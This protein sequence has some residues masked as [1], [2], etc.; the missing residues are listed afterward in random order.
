V[1]DHATGVTA[2]G[3]VSIPLVGTASL[4]GS[5][6]VSGNALQFSLTGS[7]AATFVGF[8]TTAYLTLSNAGM[9][10]TTRLNNGSWINHNFAGYVGS[11]GS[12]DISTS[13]TLNL[14]NFITGQ[15]GIATTFRF[16]STGG[17]VTLTSTA[18]V[19]LL[20]FNVTFAGNIS[21]SGFSFTVRAPTSGTQQACLTLVIVRGCVNYYYQFTLGSATGLNVQTFGSASVEVWVLGFWVGGDVG[22]IGYDYSFDASGAMHLTIRVSVLGFPELPIPIF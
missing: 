21:S 14:T 9:Y 13:G 2:A 3:S 18:T 1:V 12:F 20:G 11:N 5:L 8:N 6:S 17:S 10:M 16:R 22:G 19:A 15:T 4:S 7:T